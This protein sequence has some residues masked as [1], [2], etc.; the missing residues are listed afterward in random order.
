MWC[1][2]CRPEIFELV[3]KFWTMTL[4][5][6]GPEPRF[7]AHTIHD[8]YTDFLHRLIKYADRLARFNVSI[9]SVWK[10]CH[11][12][13]CVSLSKFELIV[14]SHAV[15]QWCNFIRAF[16]C[17]PP[18]SNLSQVFQPMNPTNSAFHYVDEFSTTHAS[19]I[20]TNL[21]WLPPRIRK[22]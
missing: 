12:Q 13:S 9:K 15:A 11:F 3:N 22:R 8:D 18:F 17:W 14:T 4:P 16:Q 2:L 10:M 7:D 20:A 19:L 21:E 1:Q 6:L 5:P